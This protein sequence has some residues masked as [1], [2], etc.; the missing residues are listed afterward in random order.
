MAF[1]AVQAYAAMLQF[2]GHLAPENEVQ[3]AP[4]VSDASGVAM[5]SIDPETFEFKGF[6]HVQRLSGPVVGYHIHRGAVG[7]SG[8]VIVNLIDSSIYDTRVETK[9]GLTK[10][11]FSGVLVDR[12]VGGVLVTK[13]AILQ[14]IL[15]GDTYFNVHTPNWPAGE[16][17]GQVQTGAGA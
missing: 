6:M 1:A 15:S 13:E 7:V 8:P 9:N 11:T 12:E 4:V 17:R 3:A 5:F 14:E 16:V 10:I 2:V